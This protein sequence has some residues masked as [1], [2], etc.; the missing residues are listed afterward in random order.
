MWLEDLLFPKPKAAIDASI[1]ANL[2]HDPIGERLLAAETILKATGV[3]I[4]LQDAA[5]PMR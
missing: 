3:K 1:R 2:Q 4:T 5:R